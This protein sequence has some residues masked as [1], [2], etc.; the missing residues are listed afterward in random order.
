MMPDEP[1]APGA[2]SAEPAAGAPG[3]TGPARPSESDAASG[4][5]VPPAAPARP[6]LDQLT[7]AVVSTARG[8][9]GR[10]LFVGWTAERLPVATTALDEL[11]PAA[12]QE[13]AAVRGAQPAA[14]Q[15]PFASLIPV[16]YVLTGSA[17]DFTDSLHSRAE[18]QI[19]YTVVDAAG[20]R[21]EVAL[22][23][24]AVLGAIVAARQPWQARRAGAVSEAAVETVPQYTLFTTLPGVR[25]D[26]GV[27]LLFDT[28]IP[29]SSNAA[30]FRSFV[31]NTIGRLLVLDES[32][33]KATRKGYLEIAGRAA[34]T[35]PRGGFLQ[36]LVTLRR[37][38]LVEIEDSW[39]QKQKLRGQKLRGQFIRSLRAMGLVEVDEQLLAELLD[40][41]P[42]YDVDQLDL[43]PLIDMAAE[44][45]RHASTLLGR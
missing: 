19:S 32:Q 45:Y 27:A 13:L 31:R 43:E 15:V 8:V 21:R 38:G 44:M 11:S 18:D 4:P 17:I 24:L 9:R 3:T 12:R 7:A 39:L 22:G 20:Q 41:R 33:P 5:A 29:G 6:L 26:A 14:R 10:W 40:P 36:T 2:G 37:M 28:T 30:A 25:A 16:A 1:P 34:G 23:E 35:P 42:E